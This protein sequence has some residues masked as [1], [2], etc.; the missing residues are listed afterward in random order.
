MLFKKLRK[1]KREKRL[2]LSIVLFCYIVTI[3]ISFHSSVSC[4]FAK[5]GVSF[6]ISLGIT[7]VFLGVGWLA[8]RW[9]AWSLA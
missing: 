3:L 5:L 1:E 8:G 4:F 2:K 6:A 7:A 9:Q